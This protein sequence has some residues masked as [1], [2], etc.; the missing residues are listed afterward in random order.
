MRAK[1]IQLWDKVLQSECGYRLMGLWYPVEKV[2]RLF[3]INC[4]INAKNRPQKNC[5]LDEKPPS[6]RMLS[7]AT[8]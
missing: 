1:G 5:V 8:A 3:A 4:E 7:F 6:E 2:S